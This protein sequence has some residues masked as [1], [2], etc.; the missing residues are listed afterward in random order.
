M[1]SAHE[2]EFIYLFQHYFSSESMSIKETVGN[3]AQKPKDVTV[4]WN[5]PFDKQGVGESVLNF[6][7]V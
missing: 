5:T 6:K 2:G 1:K 7:C 4:N 3:I